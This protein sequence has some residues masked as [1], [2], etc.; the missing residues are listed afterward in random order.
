MLFIVFGLT[1]ALWALEVAQLVGLVDVLLSAPRGQSADML[2]G[3]FYD[4]VARETRVTGV[5]FQSQM[6]VGDILVIWRASAI[7]FDKR[8]VVLL[9]LCWW[10]LMIANVLAHAA[11]CHSGVAT[12]NY[13]T[14]CKVTDVAAPTLSIVT[15]V[16]VMI[17]VLWRAWQLRDMFADVLQRKKSSRLLTVFALMVESGMLYVIVLITD[18]LIT[19]LVT[20][21]N[22]TV[23]RMVTCISGYVTVQ[24]VGMYPTLLVIVLHESLWNSNA[25]ETDGLAISTVHLTSGNISGMGSMSRSRASRLVIQPELEAGQHWPRGSEQKVELVL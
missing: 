1:T 14:L 2:F 11:R 19:S 3:R 18:L 5:V 23:G 6:I 15:N 25:E 9:P 13:G 24:L 12:T 10:I 20:G 16:S 21:E 17:L 22:E 7:W 4:L 8:T